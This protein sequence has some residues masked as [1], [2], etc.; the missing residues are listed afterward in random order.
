[1][2]PVLSSIIDPR[3]SKTKALILTWFIIFVDGARPCVC[4][5]LTNIYSAPIIFQAGTLVVAWA[6]IIVRLKSCFYLILSVW[7]A[8]A[9]LLQNESQYFP[10]SPWWM[11]Q[12]CQRQILRPPMATLATLR[13]K[14]WSR[15]SPWPGGTRVRVGDSG[16]TEARTGDSLYNYLG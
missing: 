8:C 9:F 11:L 12:R 14:N 15:P 13:A 4:D 6:W 10:F 16:C 5:V 1:M 3:P 7:I 2:V